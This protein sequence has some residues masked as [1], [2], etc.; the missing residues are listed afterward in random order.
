MRYLEGTGSW[1]SVQRRLSQRT[2]RHLEGRGY[3]LSLF[4]PSIVS[5]RGRCGTSKGGAIGYR[6]S[7]VQH[8]L[9]QRTM[10]HLEGRG[11][12]LSLFKLNLISQKEFVVRFFVGRY[13]RGHLNRLFIGCNRVDEKFIL[14]VEAGDDKIIQRT[15]LFHLTVDLR[16]SLFH[17]FLFCWCQLFYQ[18][19]LRFAFPVYFGFYFHQDRCLVGK[20]GLAQIN[21]QTLLGSL[22]LQQLVFKHV[23]QRHHIRSISLSIPVDDDH[24]VVNA[25]I[26]VFRQKD[27]DVFRPTAMYC[28]GCTQSVFLCF[29]R[30]AAQDKISV[31]I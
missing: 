12:W 18:M 16:Q 28:P 23:F 5:R 31:L 24:V 21:L 22:C 11:N 8:R 26:L 15:F 20:L 1:L 29:R 7:T 19:L 17:S 2:T 9:S 27:S 4:L 13:I 3:W 30:I 14:L 6:C 10:R 25:G